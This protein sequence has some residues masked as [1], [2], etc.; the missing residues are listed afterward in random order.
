MLY[1]KCLS[2]LSEERIQQFHNEQLKKKM[3]E[4]KMGF[5]EEEEFMIRENQFSSS[6]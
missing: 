4:K 6:N 2:C 1:L 5:Q 3:N